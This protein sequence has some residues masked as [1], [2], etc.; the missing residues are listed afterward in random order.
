MGGAE[1]C[2]GQLPNGNYPSQI[3]VILDGDGPPRYISNADMV[4]LPPVG[5][6][7]FLQ[8]VDPVDPNTDDVFSHEIM[9]AYEEYYNEQAYNNGNM[10]TQSVGEGLADVNAVLHNGAIENGDWTVGDSEHQITRNL[11]EA[12][13]LSDYDQSQSSQENGLVWGNMLY[14]LS[15]K[16]G[17]DL[18]T[19]LVKVQLG[20]W[21]LLSPDLAGDPAVF[22]I[23]DFEQAMLDA[24][25][26]DAPLQTAISEVWNDMSGSG[27]GG[28]GGNPPAAPANIDAAFYGCDPY[29]YGTIW[30]EYWSASASATFYILYY[31]EWHP[32]GPWWYVTSTPQTSQMTEVWSDAYG[33][34]R[35]CNDDGCSTLS[36]D[37]NYTPHFCF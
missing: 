4:V 7:G 22:E 29:L 10:V 37:T 8:G 21:R 30:D 23:D 34:V 36:F 20:S 27:G 13:T 3:L 32:Y 18:P 2:C 31:S 24:A 5:T 16:E 6:E 1:N 35:A 25:S 11:A 19:D 17:V 26:G 15:Q 28:G 33:K 14:R 12:K 9:H